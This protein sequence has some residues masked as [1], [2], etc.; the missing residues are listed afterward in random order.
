MEHQTSICLWY[1][2]QAEAAAGFYTRI[3]KNAK[4][5]NTVR[6]DGKVL[7]V[8]FNLEG[9]QLLGLNGG[10]TFSPNP[11]I[12]FFVTINDPDELQTLWDQLTR[13]GKIMMPLD[14]YPWSEK[15]GWVQDAF[16][17]SWQLC[18]GDEF[19]AGQKVVPMLMFCGAAQGKATEAIDFYTKVF[20]KGKIDSVEYYREGQ[21]QGVDAKVVHARFALNGDLFMAMDSGLPQPF[22]FNEGISI[23]VNCRD[24]DEIDDYWEKLTAGGGEASMCGWLKD[25][26][27][28]S[29]QI[30]P[31][32]LGLLMSAD[33]DK[34]QR[35]MAAF[36]KMKKLVIADLE[37]A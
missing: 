6:H 13:E 34:A 18:Q 28:V 17:I 36:M 37:N 26:F 31:A 27:G 29:W 24:Q 16:G 10:P 30:V 7:T 32:G 5:T 2:D 22:D 35:V 1:N 19:K 25:K 33:A 21:V 8:G 14:T 4:I 12:S 20:K 3:F 15:Y 11:T 9:T 23:I